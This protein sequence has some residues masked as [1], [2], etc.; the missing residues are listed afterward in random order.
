M[1]DFFDPGEAKIQSGG[2]D[3]NENPPV[4]PPPVRSAA[5]SGGPLTAA[6]IIDVVSG[7]P[8][9]NQRIAYDAANANLKWD[10]KATGGGGGLTS[11]SSDSTLTGDGTN[12]SPL[13]V[14]NEFTA[15]D[16]TKLDGLQNITAI[17]TGLQLSSGTLSSTGGGGDV[18]S[19]EFEA[20]IKV[21]FQIRSNPF[22]KNFVS[23]L[24]SAANEAKLFTGQTAKFGA[25]QYLAIDKGNDAHS[26]DL[27]K[28]VDVIYI[29]RGTG[30]L[31]ARVA[32]VEDDTSD[33]NIR[34]IWLYPNLYSDNLVSGNFTNG[35]GTIYPLPIFTSLADIPIVGQVFQGYW[36][37]DYASDPVEPSGYQILK[38]GKVAFSSGQQNNAPLSDVKFIRLHKTAAS[39]TNIT[40]DGVNLSRFLELCRPGGNVW[41]SELGTGFALGSNYFIFPISGDAEI[42]L[43]G[44]YWD[45]PVQ[46]PVNYSGS[47]DLDKNF[48]F[49]INPRREQ[50]LA[51]NIIS[52]V[53][54]SNI[55]TS[56]NSGSLDDLGAGKYLLGG[57]GGGVRTANLDMLNSE[58]EPYAL[59]QIAIPGY[60]YFR[61]NSS[62]ADRNNAGSVLRLNLNQYQI[63][64]KVGDEVKL[65]R[66]AFSVG[67]VIEFWVSATQNVKVLVS[68]VGSSFGKK[69]FNFTQSTG[70]ELTG[71]EPVD[72]TTIEVRGQSPHIAYDDIS[73]TLNDSLFNIP[74][75]AALEDRVF[76]TGGTTGQVVKKT[77]TGIAWSDESG[78]GSGN[79]EDTVPFAASFREVYTRNFVVSATATKGEALVSSNNS[80]PSEAPDGTTDFVGMDKEDANSVDQDS[81]LSK[82][83]AGDWIRAKVG[84]NYLIAK[85]QYAEYKANALQWIFW[86][87]P[88]TDIADTLSY[89]QLGTGSGEIR[90]YRQVDELSDSDIGDKAFSNPP[91]DLTSTEKTAVRTAIGAGTGGGSA[92]DLHD[93]V[94]T[95]V[96]SL[97]DDDRFV[98]SDE[99]ETGDPNRYA[100]LSTLKTAVSGSN[101]NFDEVGSLAVTGTWSNINSAA[102]DTT[103][104]YILTIYAVDGTSTLIRTICFKFGDLSTGATWVAVKG[105]ESGKRVNIRR[106]STN[107]QARRDVIT[108]AN[109]KLYKVENVGIK[110]NKG[111]KGDKGDPGDDGTDGD[112]ISAGS[113]ITITGSNPKT[114]AVTNEFTSADETKL[115][116][117]P[118]FFVQ[119]TA[120]TA[121][122]GDYWYD[123]ASGKDFLKVRVSGAWKRASSFTAADET[124]L[125][126]IAAGA[127]QNVQSDWNESS[128]TNDAFI[129]NKPTIPPTLTGGTGITISSNA[130][131]IDNEFTAADETK[132]DGIATGA[133]QNVQSDWNASSGDAQ[134]LNK[135]SLPTA[136][137]R[138]AWTA[139]TS[140]VVGDIVSNSSNIYRCKTAN[141]DATFTSSKWDQLNGGG[142]ASIPNMSDGYVLAGN[143]TG[144]NTAQP[145]F[146][147]TQ[148]G[149]FDSGVQALTA[150]FTSTYGDCIPLK[151]W[152]STGNISQKTVLNG[153]LL[154]VERTLSTLDIDAS[155]TVN[156]GVAIALRKSTSDPTNAY[157][158]G[159]LVNQQGTASNVATFDVTETNVPAG[160]LYWFGHSASGGTRTFSNRQFDLVSTSAGVSVSGAIS[161]GTNLT[162]DGSTL[163]ATGG[164]NLTDAQIGEKAFDNVP[165]NLTSTEKITVSTRIGLSDSQIGNKSF[166]NVPSNL[167]STEKTNART[168]IGAGTSS[169]TPALYLSGTDVRIRYGN[170]TYSVGTFY[171]S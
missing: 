107:L 4:P 97:A 129:K 133:E 147:F 22:T 137:D 159:T 121:S 170:N 37:G 67:H 64:P 125:D 168:R 74:S 108:S 71:T 11:V 106:N 70:Y 120:P 32:G 21:A 38:T 144:D 24:T 58:I 9:D 123:T 50:I 153:T 86:F 164:Q 142:E 85:I 127:E 48:L 171:T 117:L 89:D 69:Y 77:A 118:K 95:E 165:N 130:I 12:S 140:Y 110:G 56:S 115:D 52:P 99:S 46:T 44:D 75:T 152:S 132:L 14:A 79:P 45:I 60:K 16:E 113:G 5:G 2:Q 10:D 29:E 157:T 54:A 122:D 55:D 161:A 83:K 90:F 88:S 169:E 49:R 98:V 135:P 141:S 42:S 126:G 28:A 78:G 87:N 167:T 136:W 76:P 36:V 35:S 39:N 81:S 116:G 41:L 102:L 84:N 6:Q 112:T 128:N 27:I 111:D 13:G 63:V 119:A 131:N 150:S 33:S 57:Q 162:F 31:M 73:Q 139:S 101:S 15:A 158:S 82:I 156:A 109:V 134:I 105:A 61:Q 148:G 154:K 1:S 160:T 72:N 34:K 59:T 163:N 155:F 151:S 20:L 19:G 51:G 40:Q 26:V 146:G 7:N 103:Q 17:G 65:D 143:Q 145:V 104:Q 94:T 23:S 80:K 124:K 100:T 62:H 91:S 96:N 114:I 25:T 47:L 68:S 166:R 43:S 66:T 149:A 3:Q 93:D 8:T 138:G 18:T 92:F 30:R 53:E